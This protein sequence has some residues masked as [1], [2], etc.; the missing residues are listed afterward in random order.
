[1][2]SLAHSILYNDIKSEIIIIAENII[3]YE[4]FSDKYGMDWA[5]FA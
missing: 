3:V 5:V 1:M 4:I 2:F